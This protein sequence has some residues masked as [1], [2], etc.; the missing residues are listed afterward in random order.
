MVLAFAG[1]VKVGLVTSQ[2]HLTHPREIGGHRNTLSETTA[3]PTPI[4]AAPLRPRTPLE[5]AYLGDGEE[6]GV[7]RLPWVLKASPTEIAAMG[8]GRLEPWQRE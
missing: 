6:R 8:G 3:V 2:R 5:L 4:K 1:F 7:P